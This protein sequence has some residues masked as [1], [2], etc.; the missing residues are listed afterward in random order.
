MRMQWGEVSLSRSIVTSDSRLT[1]DNAQ[2]TAWRTQPRSCSINPSIGWPKSHPPVVST[3][4][5]RKTRN[6]EDA[7]PA[8]RVDRS[9]D[10]VSVVSCPSAGVRTWPLGGRTKRSRLSWQR[11]RHCLQV[12]AKCGSQFPSS[13]VSPKHRTSEPHSR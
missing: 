7:E 11:C 5:K 12:D 2:A 4:S 13:P 10:L 9:G 3:S 8:G 6:W 1:V